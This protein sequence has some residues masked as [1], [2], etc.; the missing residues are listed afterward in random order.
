MRKGA[1]KGIIEIFFFDG[2]PHRRNPLLDLVVR[3]PRPAL[4]A[5][6]ATP[7]RSR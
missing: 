7:S 5:Q 6:D 1:A 3:G 4:A 2:A